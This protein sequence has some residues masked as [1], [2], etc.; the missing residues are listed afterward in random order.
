[1]EIEKL[2]GELKS[3]VSKLEMAMGKEESSEVKEEVSEG[4]IAPESD[5]DGAM[6]KK[7]LMKAMMGD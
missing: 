2:L 5:A 7:M 1:M 3:V 6:K 4:E